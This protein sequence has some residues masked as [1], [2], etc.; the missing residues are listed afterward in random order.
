ME[1]APL[2]KSIAK[3]FHICS[4]I[5]NGCTSPTSNVVDD[6]VVGRLNNLAQTF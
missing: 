4:G 1:E 2:M 6:L 3:S 5:G